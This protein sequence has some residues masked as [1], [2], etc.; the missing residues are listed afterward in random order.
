MSEAVLAGAAGLRDRAA[1]RPVWRIGAAG[2]AAWLAAAMLT[3][4]WPDADDLGRTDLL[5]V[6][7]I[8][9]WDRAG[10]LRLGRPGCAPSRRGYGAL[11]RGWWRWP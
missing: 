9:I 1:R 10:G 2:S 11:V 6:I 7:M 3:A 8:G 5:A 4:Y